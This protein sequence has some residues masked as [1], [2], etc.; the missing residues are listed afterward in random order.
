M[1]KR[2]SALVLLLTISVTSLVACTPTKETISDTTN[3]EKNVLKDK[4]TLVPVTLNEVAHSIFYAPM[5]VAIEEGYFSENG[6]DLTLITGF[7]VIQ[8]VQNFYTTILHTSFHHNMQQSNR[9]ES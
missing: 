2:I 7:G 3:T 1:K 8:L 9:L 6:I 5:Y 4:K